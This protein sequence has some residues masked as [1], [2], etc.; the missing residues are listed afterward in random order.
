MTELIALDHD[1]VVFTD[2]E[3]AAVTWNRKRF[4]DCTFERCSLPESTLRDVSF[5]GCTFHA[6]DLTA[7]RLFDT[8]FRGVTF[9]ACRLAGVDWTGARQL[10]FDARFEDSSLRFGSFLEMRLDK[11]VMLRCDASEV[12]FSDAD[13]TGAT[14]DGTRLTRANFSG[15]V[16]TDA[17]L[18]DAIDPSFVPSRVKLGHTRISMD[19]AWRLLAEMGL[20]VDVG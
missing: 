7:V 15:A 16:L 20:E 9:R 13:L 1:G 8:A 11:L 10:L 14:F 19:L 6:C 17:Q 18:Q 3:L 2:L 5:D 12:D 4:T